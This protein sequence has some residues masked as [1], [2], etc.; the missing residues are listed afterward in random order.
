M[1]VLTFAGVAAL[2]T[3]MPGPDSLLVLRTAVAHGRRPALLA[4]LGIQ[5]GCLWWGAAAGLGLS[6]VLAASQTLYTAVRWAGACYLLYLGVRL[7]LQRADADDAVE[8][9]GRRHFL[10]GLLTNALNPKVGVF[11]VSLLPQFV[12]HDAP[13]AAWSLLLTGVHVAEGLLWCTAIAVLADRLGHWL[14]RRSLR[15]ALDRLSG[16]AFVAFAARL[17]LHP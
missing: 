14:R 11:Y 5:T 7:L 2:L 3:L 10:R 6:A 4:A 13:V 1:T 12:P 8:P 15:R 16:T 17:A 9:P